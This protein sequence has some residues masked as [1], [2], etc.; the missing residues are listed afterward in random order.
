MSHHIAFEGKFASCPLK[1]LRTL[2]TILEF[3]LE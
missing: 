3:D 1:E 2:Y